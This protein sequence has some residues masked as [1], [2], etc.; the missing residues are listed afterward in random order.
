MEKLRT[1]VGAT[2][3]WKEVVVDGVK[4]AYNDEGVGPV[5]VCLHAI[6]HGA[7]DFVGLRTRLH[8][9]YRVI[10]LDWP[11]QGRSAEDPKP[12]SAARYTEL[13]TQFLDGVG[14]DHA[15]IIG[16]SIG[17]A[18]A[19]RYGSINPQRVRALVLVNPAGLDRNDRIARLVTQL[20]VRF[21][22]A[23]VRGARWF[24]AAFAAYYH[25]VLPE[26]PAA[27]QRARIVASAHEIA[28][29]LV[30]AWQSFGEPEADI[31][32]RA[33][34]I[35]YPVLFTWATRDRIIQLRRNLPAIRRFPNARLETFRA[36]HAPF[37]ETPEAFLQSVERFLTAQQSALV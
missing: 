8:E 25:L 6:G 35:A 26:K 22:C 1:L 13:L 18:V 33:A 31:R 23:G 9:H 24:P 29:I 36:G 19:M 37:L 5:I 2:V 7:G 12:A 4:L 34:H 32:S 20:M 10:A 27:E 3:P 21:F 17:G 11:G 28:P 30:Q 15:V 14:I 16:N